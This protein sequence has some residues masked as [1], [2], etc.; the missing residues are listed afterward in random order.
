MGMTADA[1][2]V[3]V[4]VALVGDD[5]VLDAHAA[6]AEEATPLAPTIH[7]EKDSDPPA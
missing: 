1:G 7:D 4:V 5:D 3:T 2:T 6:T